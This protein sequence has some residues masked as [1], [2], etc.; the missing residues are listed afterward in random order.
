MDLGCTSVLT[1][2]NLEGVIMVTSEGWSVKSNFVEGV[3]VRAIVVMG[4]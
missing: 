4:T 1:Q 2:C 3:A